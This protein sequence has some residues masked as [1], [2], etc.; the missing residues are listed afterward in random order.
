[1]NDSET[2]KNLDIDAA[3]ASQPTSINDETILIALHKARLELTSMPT[4]LRL[5]SAEWLRARGYAGLYG[6]PLPPP[7]ELPQ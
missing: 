6:V 3:R 5:D 4:N 7:G 2:V 1:M